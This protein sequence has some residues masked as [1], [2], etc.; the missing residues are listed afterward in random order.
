MFRYAPFGP[1]WFV[2]R[3]LH[4]SDPNPVLF[5]THPLQTTVNQTG[6]PLGLHHFNKE[7]CKYHD[8]SQ[9]Y[10]EQSIMISFAQRVVDEDAEDVS[11]EWACESNDNL[12]EKNAKRAAKRAARS[13]ARTKSQAGHDH[14]KKPK[15]ASVT[16]RTPA[17][18]VKKEEEEDMD[19]VPIVDDDDGMRMTDDDFELESSGSS[20]I[21]D[22]SVGF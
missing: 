18:R 6:L 16:A 15:A 3:C 7:K 11:D 1:G 19:I 13:A 9:T 17:V 21:T 22:D 5:K 14:R 12:K 2:L 4:A 10:T 20:T 8:H